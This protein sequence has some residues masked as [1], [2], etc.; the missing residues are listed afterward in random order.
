M[1]DVLRDIETYFDAVPRTAARGETVGPFTLFINPGPGW[2]Y[3]ARPSLGSSVFT[4]YDVAQVRDRQQELGLPETIEWVAETSPA[5]R[6]PVEAA[7]F[8]VIGHPLLVLDEGQMR[9]V[10]P[11][12]AEV[13]RVTGHEDRLGLYSSVAAIAFAHAGTAIGK[14]GAQELI[15]TADG[16]SIES[17]AFER[18]RLLDGST[19]MYA[20]CQDG[21]PV[22]IGSHQPVGKVT[23]L[24]GIATLP[25]YRRRGLAA[26]VTQALVEDALRRGMRTIFLS[27]DDDAVA[28]IYESVGFRRLA[29]A[30][31]AFIPEADTAH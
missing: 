2:T 14:E 23:E 15:A 12:G 5:L 25:A 6:D 31:V 19:V 8:Q 29:T 17:V 26:A 3:Y 24:V 9:T 7:G 20:A 11:A 10:V 4:V 27:A 21:Y 13:L 16:R 28:R 18:K 22:A 30:C 1:P